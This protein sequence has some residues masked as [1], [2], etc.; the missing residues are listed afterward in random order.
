MATRATAAPP[1]LI[2]T[3]TLSPTPAPTPAPATSTRAPGIEVSHVE[4][5]TQD[6]H[7]H[8]RALK[9]SI[10]PRSPRP[11]TPPTRQPSEKIVLQ[12]EQARWRL[13]RALVSD[14][15][16]APALRDTAAPTSCR[17]YRPPA[18][19]RIYSLV[20]EQRATSA[21][22]CCCCCC[23]SHNPF[24]LARSAPTRI[25]Q[26]SPIR[27]GSGK[28]GSSVIGGRSGFDFGVGFGFGFGGVSTFIVSPCWCR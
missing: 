8:C 3:S 12:Q 13:P 5:I 17:S 22:C 18:V 10:I 19:S 23:L 16:C 21:R 26:V 15:R 27:Q 7:R 1:K 11:R 4:R 24:H 25:A 20:H 6:R 14:R 28:V 2:T 9:L